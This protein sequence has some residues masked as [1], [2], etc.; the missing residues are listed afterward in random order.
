MSG[1]IGPGIDGVA[2]ALVYFSAGAIVAGA[3][4]YSPVSGLNYGP[5]ASGALIT[6]G[7]GVGG[8]AT[9]YAISL[10]FDRY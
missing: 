1:V 5:Y 8:V 2:K 4:L 6:A 10:A 7:S 3:L 9:L